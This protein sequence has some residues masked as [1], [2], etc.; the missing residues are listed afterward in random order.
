MNKYSIIY[1]PLPSDKKHIM[2]NPV[3]IP[4]GHSACFKCIESY[5][6]VNKVF[7]CPFNCTTKFSLDKLKECMKIKNQLIIS[8]IHAF[9]EEIIY[10]SLDDLTYE[11]TKT[12]SI[13]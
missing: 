8:T 10:D 5:I 1:C 11:L 4:C 9:I 3:M 7:T 6:H 2:S 12:E 13:V